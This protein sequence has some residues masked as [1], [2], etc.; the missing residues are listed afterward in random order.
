M[1]RFFVI[2]C[3]L[4]ACPLFAQTGP[5]PPGFAPP[6]SSMRITSLPQEKPLNLFEAREAI[7]RYAG[8]RD[9]LAKGSGYKQLKRWEYLWNH[10][11]DSR[12]NLPTA[13]E[14]W[15]SWKNKQQASAKTPNPTADWNPVGP[16]NVGVYSGQL[17]GT[18][19][20]N[21][22]AVDPVNPDIWYVGAPAGGIWKT[23]DAGSNWTNLFDDFPQIGVSGIAIDPQDPNIVY[24]ATGDDDAADS[25]S[26]GVFKSTDGGLTWNETGINPGNTDVNLLMN[27]IVIDPTDSQV[28]WVGSSAG[29]YKSSDGGSS[30]NLMQGGFISDFKLKPGD[31]NTVYAVS[32]AHVGGGGGSASYY[33]TTNGKDFQAIDSPVLPGTSGRVVLGVTPADPEVLYILTANRASSNF[34]YQGLYRSSD[35]GET[36]T[37]TQNNQN[38]MESSQAWFDLALTVD[39]VNANILYMGCLNIWKS[40]NGGDSWSRLNSWFRNNAAYTHA[41]I[42]RLEIFGNRLFACT[43]GGVYVSENGGGTF[44]DYT[45][46]ITI[47]QFYKLSVSAQDASKMIGGLQ[48]NGGQVLNQGQWNNYHGGDGMDNAVDPVND[49][50]MYGFT[51][52]GGSLNISTDSGQSIAIIGPPTNNQGSPVPGNWITPMA[53]APDGNLY[54]GYDAIYR[55]NGN[56]WEKRYEIPNTDGRIEDLEADPS[57]ASVLYAAEG[58]FVYR[59][60]D[61][62]MNFAPF[63]NARAEITDMAVNSRDGSAIYVVTSKRVGIPQ[64]EQLP[65]DRKVFRVP[66][67]PN[68][69][70]GLETDIT[71]DLPT[72]QAFFAITHQGRHTE[73][74][75]YL[76]TNLGV[77]RLDDNLTSWEEYF[78]GLPSTA[79]SDLE[80]SL[81]DERITASTYGRGVWQSP[82]PVQVPD[83][84]IRLLSLSPAN[85]AVICSAVVPRVTVENNGLN[86]IT[87][88]AITYSLNAGTPVALNQVVDIPGGETAEVE[89][90]ELT[91]LQKGKAVL[92]VTVN[93]EGDAFED[94]NSQEH[95]FYVNSPGT[96]DQVNDFESGSADLVT[97]NEG[98]DTEQW[99]RGTP[100]GTLLNQAASGSQAYATNL[101]GNHGDGVKAFLISECYDFSTIL[102]PVLKFNMAYDLEQDFDIVYV[103]F[104]TDEG[105]TWELLGSVDSQP[106]WYTSDRTNESS[107]EA[108][109]CQNCPGAQWTGTNAE[110]TEYAYDFVLNAALGER[111]L[112]GEPNIQFRIVF[113]SDPLVTQEGAVVDDLVVSGFEDDLDD[114]NDGIPDAEDNCPLIPNPGQDDTDGDGI[115]NSCDL[116]DDGD[117]I[118]DTTDNCPLTPNADQADADADGIGDVCDDDLDNDG[119]PND[120]D[121][122]PATPDGQVVG[123]DGCPVFSLP[124]ANFLIRTRGETCSSKNDG[125]ILLEAAEALDYTAVLNGGTV[126]D[127]TETAEFSNLPAGNYT[128]CI[129]VAGEP[130]YRQCYQLEVVQPQ[131]LSVSGKVNSLDNAITLELAGGDQYRILL[132]G[133]DYQTTSSRITLPLDRPVNQLEVRTDKDCQGVYQQV[134]TLAESL[135]VLPN[136]VADGYFD[137]FLPG[138]LD[139]RVQLGLFNLDGRRILHK[140]YN[141][142]QGE[143]RIRMDGFAPGVYLLNIGVGNQLF[144]YKI[145]KR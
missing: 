15:Q 22:V 11:A 115:G 70:P 45:D 75:V 91:S 7:Q 97:Y 47:G 85:S 113:H 37:E 72:D 101:D 23:T 39:P 59:S 65:V 68:G 3:L 90:P 108:D 103:Q 92:S 124:A 84:D 64:T 122:C 54:A 139:G 107:G 98:S 89:L 119:V 12:G 14:L 52:F 145:I 25:Y 144:T 136:P 40:N 57:N 60:A 80:I 63:F 123:I 16:L 50:I 135:T 5:V 95:T 132:N 38:I 105:S 27:D 126:L 48:D 34:S 112:T 88:I 66:V 93:V 82:I 28:L 117:G 9:V 13:S 100:A 21:T 17:P 129:T 142:I 111:D 62:G 102:A 79:V 125:A 134:I 44:R 32:N 51:Q 121:A 114:D 69:D 55:L 118:P 87:E 71:Y 130:D 49:N 127:F 86:P 56:Q 137:V 67:L 110:L 109:D 131:D 30:W 73:N 58:T 81:D 36:F 4:A 31:P 24:I 26:V 19:R 83:S 53:I 46:G 94:N 140:E 20:L 96:S 138:D 6:D 141:A 128:L 29:L 43:D 77:Y 42:H 99:E 41:D 35:S 143:I 33:K 8:Q 76:G 61:G 78:A 106:N 2:A 10:F 74:P 116:D 133:K 1:N 18:G 120:A 104:S